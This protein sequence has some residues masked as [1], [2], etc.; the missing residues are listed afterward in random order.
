MTQ[1]VLSATT[2]EG[3]HI[4]GATAR[5]RPVVTVTIAKEWNIYLRIIPR[6]TNGAAG[7]YYVGK[8][9]EFLRLFQIFW[10]KSSFIS[11]SL[12]FFARFLLLAPWK[13][14]ACSR[15]ATDASIMALA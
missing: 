7:D 12:C 14:R 10:A 8:V 1:R 4:F 13:G 9:R 15:A 2:G 11:V 3:T 6:S 5:V